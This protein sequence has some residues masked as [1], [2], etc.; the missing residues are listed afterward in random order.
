MLCS[1]IMKVSQG[2][3][4]AKREENPLPLYSHGF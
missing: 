2:L 1:S 3:E 4:P